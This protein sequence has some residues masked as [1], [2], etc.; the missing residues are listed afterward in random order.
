MKSTA[1]ASPTLLLAVLLQPNTAQGR[2]LSVGFINNSN[3]PLGFR[4]RCRQLHPHSANCPRVNHSI[5][6]N[7]KYGVGE[8][9]SSKLFHPS[10]QLA[11]HHAKI[12]LMALSIQQFML[13]TTTQCT[14]Y[15]KNVLLKLSPLIILSLA[16]L[17]SNPI[18]SWASS[19]SNN[20]LQQSSSADSSSYYLQNNPQ[21]NPRQSQESVLSIQTQKSQPYSSDSEYRYMKRRHSRSNANKK[22]KVKRMTTF[23]MLATL[24]AS[25]FRASLRKTK[26]VRNTSPFGRI[27]NASALGNGVSVIRV[28]MALGFDA[29][30][31]SG[32]SSDGGTEDASS[33]LNRL[34]LEDKELYTNIAKLAQQQ[35]Q[36]QGADTYGLRQKALG[37]YLS[38][39]EY[40]CCCM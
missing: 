25:T 7:E 5:Q 2:E 24:A 27:R 35:T 1:T 13:K 10:H 36:L 37:T 40:L 3:G 17:L 33:L 9:S 30:H 4:S 19:S 6:T 16:F 12:N 8:R 26:V 11:N 22:Q 29:K 32:D 20:L 23:V 34:G 14:E 28:C 39:G 18:N 21:Y 31:G 38:N 15:L